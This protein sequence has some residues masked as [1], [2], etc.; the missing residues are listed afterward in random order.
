MRITGLYP[1]NIPFEIFIALETIVPLSVLSVK[2]IVVTFMR[3]LMAAIMIAG[4]TYLK[5]DLNVKC[6]PYQKAHHA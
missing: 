5:E 4:L 6:L 2:I 3:V 1:W